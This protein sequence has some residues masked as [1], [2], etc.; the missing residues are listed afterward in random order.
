MKRK[1]TADELKA[2]RRAHAAEKQA[3]E[4]LRRKIHE[5]S[6]IRTPPQTPPREPSSDHGSTAGRMR[7]AALKSLRTELEHARA[8]LA[9]MRLRSDHTEESHVKA[10][11][12]DLRHAAE[13]CQELHDEVAK[14]KKLRAESEGFEDG[15]ERF[16]RGGDGAAGQIS[17]GGR[18]RGRAAAA[19]RG[20]ASLQDMA[21][22]SAAPAPAPAARRARGRPR[23]PERTSSEKESSLRWTS[24][25][26]LRVGSG[27]G[28]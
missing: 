4:E 1:N 24:R 23:G 12:H 13:E 2:C 19:G 26:P 17:E 21:A 5:A 8:A 25:R 9:E 11:Q 22:V 7:A 27:R 28:T 14:E 20:R 18:A 3:A 10:L 6:A 16:R 15:A